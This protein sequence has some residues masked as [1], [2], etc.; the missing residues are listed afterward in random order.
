MFGEVKPAVTPNLSALATN[1]VKQLGFLADGLSSRLVWRHVLATTYSPNYLLENASGI[2]QGWP[3]IPLPASENLLRASAALGEQLAALL[4]PDTPAP[5]VTAGTIRP[6]LAAI[7]VPSTQPGATRDWQLAGWGNQ[8]QTG[9]MP[10]RGSTTLRDYAPAEAVTAAHAAL[11]GARTA[12]IGMNP[13]S[14]WRNI[15]EQVWETHIGGYQVLKKWLSYRD[16]SIL[17]RPLSEAEVQ[18]VTDT[19]RRLAAILLL[20]PAL[21]ASHHACAAAHVPLP[22]P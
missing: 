20:G 3:R 2:R 16:A 5:G 15:P 8:T 7:A 9:V 11:L 22:S 6:E 4:D 1:W 12:D 19:A 17:H 21:D 13:A 10:G 14:F 18:H